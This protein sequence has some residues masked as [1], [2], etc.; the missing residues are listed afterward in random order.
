M[1]SKLILAF[2]PSRLVKSFGYAI[3]GI[4]SV[5]LHERNMH[6]HLFAA[7][8]VIIV[9]FLLAISSLEWCAVLLCIAMVWTAELFN[10]ALETLTDLVSPDYNAQ[11]GKAKD[12]AAGAVLLASLWAVVIAA[13][14]FLPK[15]YHCFLVFK[16]GV[17]IGS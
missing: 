9:G 8:L 4:A 12:I 16:N 13:I 6:V 7:L 2:S 11:A 10:S 5:F 1:L 15:I 3:R 14:I 17:V